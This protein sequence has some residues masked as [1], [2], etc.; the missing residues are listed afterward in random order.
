M[1]TVKKDGGTTDLPFG[2]ANSDWVELKAKWQKGDNFL[3]MKSSDRLAK[4]S[5]FYM[6]GHA[7]VRGSCVIGFIKGAVS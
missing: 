4:R 2:Y 7:L 3:E 5:K 6:D 1:I